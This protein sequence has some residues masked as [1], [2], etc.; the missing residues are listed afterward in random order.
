MSS[1]GHQVQNSFSPQLDR[2]FLARSSLKSLTKE[3]QLFPSSTSGYQHPSVSFFIVLPK[4]PCPQLICS[5]L[6]SSSS[7][8]SSSLSLSLGGS[9]L[10]Q[11]HVATARTQGHRHGLGQLVDAPQQLRPSTVG[12]KS[13]LVAGSVSR[14]FPWLWTPS[15]V[16]RLNL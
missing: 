10:V 13:R 3:C 11:E 4:K 16:Q 1:K 5:T 6:P 12:A 2:H 8:S 9:R 14:S 7:S 15:G